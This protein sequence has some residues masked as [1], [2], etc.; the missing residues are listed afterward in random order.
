MQFRRHDRMPHTK[1]SLLLLSVSHS[2]HKLILPSLV[3]SFVRVRNVMEMRRLN[4]QLTDVA[5]L[6][7]ELLAHIGYISEFIVHGIGP[8]PAQSKQN[9]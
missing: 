8:M 1:K 9:S 4:I 3:S 7:H 6:L 5:T 2:A